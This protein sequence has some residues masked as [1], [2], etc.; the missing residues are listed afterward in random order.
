M[1]LDDRD[2]NG[3]WVPYK[4]HSVW[5]H[6]E[7]PVDPCCSWQSHDVQVDILVR[8]HFQEKSPPFQ[9]LIIYPLQLRYNFK[10]QRGEVK[11]DREYRQCCPA[12]GGPPVHAIV[13]AKSGAKWVMERVMR[14]IWARFYTVRESSSR[15]GTVTSLSVSS[16]NTGSGTSLDRIDSDFERRR[17]PLYKPQPDR[18]FSPSTVSVSSSNTGSGIS[19]DRIES[20]F[21][22]ARERRRRRP[23]YKPQPD[24]NPHN[25]EACLLRRCPR[26]WR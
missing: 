17:R 26:P 18:E 8:E 15:T 16:S 23:L 25:C 24:H 20:D 14:F 9:F 3:F 1:I 6:F 4:C 2:K 10:L 12:H 13:G 7:C 19:L 22:T 5:G 21:E 11:I